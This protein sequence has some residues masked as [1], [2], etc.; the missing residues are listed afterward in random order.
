MGLFGGLVGWMVGRWRAVGR[1][2]CEVRDDEGCYE[3]MKGRKGEMRL[4]WNEM[5]MDVE[6]VSEVELSIDA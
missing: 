3:E 1:T 4:V 5:K 6:Q 2:G